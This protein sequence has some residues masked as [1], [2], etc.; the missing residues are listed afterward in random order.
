[1]KEQEINVDE[2]AGAIQEAYECIMPIKEIARGLVNDQFKNSD[3]LQACTFWLMG[4][5][6]F[7]LEDNKVE[8]FKKS[9]ILKM[10]KVVIIKS[11]LTIEIMVKKGLETDIIEKLK[12][13]VNKYGD[14]EIWE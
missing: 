13:W 12:Q 10:T 6:R 1:M 2:L 4:Y 5:M 11:L 7:R 3:M 9:L 14:K 8:I